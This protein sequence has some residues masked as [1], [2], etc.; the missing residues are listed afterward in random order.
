MPKND[1]REA[2]E[3]FFVRLEKEHP[4]P[5]AKRVVYAFIQE[6]GSLRISVPDFNDIFRMQRDA[7]IRAAFNGGNH[8]EL[9]AR[10]GMSASQIRRIVKPRGSDR[11]TR[12][13]RATER[14]TGDRR[15]GG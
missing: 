1:N 3:S 6:C 12:E 9:M 5:V 7:K 13:R 15:K 2:L 14:L 4:L 11:R 10:W 8:K